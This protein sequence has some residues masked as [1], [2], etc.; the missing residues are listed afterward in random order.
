[1]L[2]IP[3]PAQDSGAGDAGDAGD[4]GAVIDAAGDAGVGDL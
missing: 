2:V 4:D 3:A 1:V